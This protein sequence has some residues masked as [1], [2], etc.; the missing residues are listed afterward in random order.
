LNQTG[1]LEDQFV[2]RHLELLQRLVEDAA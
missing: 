2:Q 1:S